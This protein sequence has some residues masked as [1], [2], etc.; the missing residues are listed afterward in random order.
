MVGLL[1][2]VIR[3]M[4]KKPSSPPSQTDQRGTRSP[5]Y[6]A[7]KIEQNGHLIYVTT[8]PIDDLFEYCVVERRNENPTEGFQRR[9][10]ESRADEIA[11]YLNSEDN[12]IP[13]NIVLSAQSEA[14]FVHVRENKAI[15]FKRVPGAFVIL[16]GQHR[17]WGYQKCAARHRVPVAIYEGLSRPDEARLFVDIN[18]KHQGV[19]KA[20]ILDVKSLAG[21]ESDEER[22]LRELFDRLNTDE[23]S[24]LH[25]KLSAAQST[26][27]KLSRLA[28]NTAL[29]RALKRDSLR[30]VSSK[31][32]QYELVVKFLRAFHEEISDKSLLTK[33]H[34]L[35][36]IFDLFDEIVKKAK[37]EHGS[38]TLDSLRKIISPISN[39]PDACLPKTQKRESLVDV[40]RNMLNSDTSI[41]DDDI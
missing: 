26:S 18:T 28:F 13:I 10:S 25:N 23:D 34:F 31:D 4:S 20:L 29:I 39:I 9:L 38:V 40:M 12:S 11:E 30:R 7:L 27:G 6:S 16:D 36:A 1:P 17:M 15:S 35:S 37:K 24:P 33:K 3:V 22:L 2:S 14:E 32:K 5:G 8:I 21:S 41:S 19:S